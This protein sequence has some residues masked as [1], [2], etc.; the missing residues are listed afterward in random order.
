MNIT[1]TG[2]TMTS[3]ITPHSARGEGGGWIPTWL[4]GRA[5]TRNQAITAMVLA[6]AVAEGSDHTGKR[7][8]FIEGWA[9]ELGITG[10]DAVTKINHYGADPVPGLRTYGP[11]ERPAR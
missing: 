11:C 6:E 9:D 10:T 7:W 2:E 5:L 4:P 8:P 3:D 1:I